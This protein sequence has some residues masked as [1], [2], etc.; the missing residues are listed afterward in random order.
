[1]TAGKIG[2]SFRSL[3]GSEKVEDGGFKKAAVEVNV[4]RLICES[5]GGA[6]GG[7]HSWSVVPLVRAGVAG[8]QAGKYALLTEG[9]TGL[10]GSSAS[11]QMTVGC[12]DDVVDYTKA[13][14]ASGLVLKK[15][16]A[17][18]M[19]MGMGWENGR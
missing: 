12:V 14:R 3:D 13:S 11:I 10:S 15:R 6:A 7:P 1:M 5:R 17:G 4:S 9:E 2:R 16:A 8:W 18:R 19:R